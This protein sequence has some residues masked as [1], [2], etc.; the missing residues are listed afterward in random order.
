MY[1]LYEHDGSALNILFQ[2]EHLIAIHKPAGLL[3]HRSEID[4]YETHFA[5]Q[6]LRDQIGQHVYPIHRLDKPT[7]GI[8]LFAL[9]PDVARDMQTLFTEQKIT[10]TY[11]ALVRGFAPESLFIDHP[12]KAVQDKKYNEQVEAKDAQTE[13]TTIKQFIL[14][15]SVD[16]KY[17]QSRYSLVNLKP[18]TGRRHQLRYH[19]K[20]ISHPIIGD[21]K[22]GKG[23]HNRF[24]TEQFGSNR[25]LLCASE[26][27][28]EHPFKQTHTTI[29]TE[30]D[31]EFSLL[32]EQLEKVCI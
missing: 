20:H 22:Y 7:S 30:L 11:T 28:F 21:A 13:L 25:L 1:K 17:T 15:Y 5:L 2:D 26:I 6:M 14:P 4:K 31:N 29:K 23:R 3:V 19:M 24:F 16:E 18:I 9:S 12:V 27:E 8:L 10:K 32:L